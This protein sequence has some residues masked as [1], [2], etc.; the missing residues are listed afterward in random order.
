MFRALVKK[1]GLAKRGSY[2]FIAEPMQVAQS[3]IEKKSFLS[4]TFAKELLGLWHY[5]ERFKVCEKPPLE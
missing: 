3:I 5:D 2:S 4:S 1:L